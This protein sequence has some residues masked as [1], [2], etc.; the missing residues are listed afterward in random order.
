MGLLDLF[1]V[2]A[3]LLAIVAKLLLHE[4]GEIDESWM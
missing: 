3:W 2:R 1:L 4:E